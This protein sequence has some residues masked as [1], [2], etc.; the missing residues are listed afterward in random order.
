MQ[1]IFSYAPSQA[2]PRISFARFIVNFS[3]EPTLAIKYLTQA[4]GMKKSIVDQFFMYRYERLL[5]ESCKNRITLEEG[6]AINVLNVMRYEK[7]QRDFNELLEESALLHMQYWATL[8]D[9]SP[10]M[11]K[12]CDVG[13]KILSIQTYI[14]RL[15]RKIQLIYPNNPKDLLAYSEYLNQVWNDQEFAADI[16][17][18]YLLKIIYEIRAKD[19]AYS[20]KYSTIFTTHLQD[21]TNFSMDGVSCVYMSG[22]RVIIFII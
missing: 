21:I 18:K 17:E 20:N 5:E 6:Q 4:R 11:I 12:M 13:F 7:L 9:E 2:T 15:W 3:K 19:S 16:S 22:D 10:S 1:N 14:D 8:L